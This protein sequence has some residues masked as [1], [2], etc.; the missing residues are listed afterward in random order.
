MADPATKKTAQKPSRSEKIRNIGIAAHIDAGKTTLS[1]RILFYSGRI[2]ALHEV[3]EGLATMDYLPQEQERGIT[4]T[5]AVT[6]IPWKGYELHLIDTPGHVDFTVEVERSLRVLDG[7]IAVF[8]GVEGVEPQSETV[9]SQ[10]DRYKVPRLAFINKLDRV[11]ADFVRS[12]ESIHQK[13]GA[14]PIPVQLPVGLEDKFRGVLDLIDLKLLTFAESDQGSTV[15]AKEIPAELAGEAQAGRERLIELLA[16][17]DDAVAEAFLEGKE[18]SADELRAGLRRVTL[19]NRAVPTLCG[20]ALKNKGVQPLLDAVVA[21]LPSPLDVPPIAG[22]HPKTG[23]ELS[24]PPEPAA[25]FCALAF[26]VQR[27]E[28]RKLTLFRIYSGKIREGDDV[29]NPRLKKREKISRMFSLHAQQRDKK[30]SA[31]AGEIVAAMGLKETTTGDTICSE[32]AP[33]VL[34][35]IAFREPVISFAVEPESQRDEEKLL[36]SLGAACEEDPTLKLKRDPDTGQILLAGMGELHLEVVLD[37]ITRDSDLKVRA[38]RPQVVLRETV[39]RTARGHGLFERQIE[40][41]MLYAEV[42]VEV[43]PRGRNE[44]VTHEQALPPASGPQDSGWVPQSLAR[45]AFEGI[46]EASGAGAMGYPL[47]DTAVRLVGVRYREKE[48]TVPAVRSAAAEA[49]HKALRD[50]APSLLEPIVEVSVTTPEES[51]GEVLGDLNARRG[52]IFDVKDAPAKKEVIARLPL[53]RLFGYSTALRSLTQGRGN[54]MMKVVGFD[55]S[56]GSE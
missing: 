5:S 16:D 48:T 9:W 52:Q 35:S 20:S 39:T 44:G 18:L 37:R 7:M 26:K 36:E 47:V 56:E 11:G 17:V 21:Y 4:I 42:E 45:A 34:E 49:L 43:A 51:F 54:F 46:K 31:E 29:Y 33:I 24:R 50:A 19:S 41:E 40:D 25:P 8:D 15:D 10:A 27:F 53:R 23:E 2:R 12:V 32:G 6:S 3:H 28:G 30:E 13:L 38:G 55:L 14:K 1:E 22:T